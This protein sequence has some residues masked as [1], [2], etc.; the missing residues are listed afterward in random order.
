MHDLMNVVIYDENQLTLNHTALHIVES[1][2]FLMMCFEHIE[3]YEAI[4]VNEIIF[5]YW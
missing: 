4:I 5:L 1:E 2:V 3:N